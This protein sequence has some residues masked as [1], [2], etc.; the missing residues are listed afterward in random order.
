[1]NKECE[2]NFEIIEIINN[3]KELWIC[4]KCKIE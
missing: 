4:E 2:H 3:E 1:M